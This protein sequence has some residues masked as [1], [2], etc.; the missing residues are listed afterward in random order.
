MRN[1]LKFLFVIVCGGVPWFLSAQTVSATVNPAA[2]Y[3]TSTGEALDDASEPQSAP[4]AGHFTSNVSDLGDYSVRYEWRVYREGQENS[5]IIDRFDENLD[6]TFTESG[7]FYVQLYAT[8]VSGNDTIVFPEE[9]AAEPFTVSISE[10]VLE[11]P[12]AFS[13]NGDGYNDVYKVKEGYKSIVSFKAVIFNRWGQKLYSW[14]TLDG[15]WDGKFHGKTV[16]DGV[17][18]VVVNA[19]G[20]DGKEYKI[21][22]D[23]NVLTGYSGTGTNGNN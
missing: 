20:S 21:R 1:Y 12:N 6:Y 16:K 23:V 8:F 4:L 7:T 14:D 5:P 18:F 19:L 9:G 17:Y 3:T 13:P 2:S 11:F 10:S 15:G 22:K